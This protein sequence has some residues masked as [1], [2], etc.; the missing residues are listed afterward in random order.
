MCNQVSKLVFAAKSRM[1]D[2]KPDLLSNRHPHEQL[3]YD[4]I[5][6][7]F[8]SFFGIMWWAFQLSGETWNAWKLVAQIDYNIENHSTKNKKMK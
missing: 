1:L 6:F 7:Y 2:W 5:F 8:H 3:N 4:M